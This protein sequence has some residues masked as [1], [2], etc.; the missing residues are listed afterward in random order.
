MTVDAATSPAK[1]A[2]TAG[3][4]GDWEPDGR[5]QPLICHRSHIL[6]TRGPLFFCCR[7]AARGGTCWRRSINDQSRYG[8]L[9]PAT[10]HATGY[11]T[12]TPATLPGGCRQ[13]PPRVS[14]GTGSG[15]RSIVGQWWETLGIGHAL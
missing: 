9:L 14:A 11:V 12:R 4:V 7:P 2:S 10:C 8:R 6:V 1:R 3:S 13:E 5:V 15:P